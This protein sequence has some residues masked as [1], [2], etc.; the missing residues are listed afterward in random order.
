MVDE[1]NDGDQATPD[2]QNGSGHDETLEAASVPE[3]RYLRSDGGTALLKKVTLA[4]TF[5]AGAAVAGGIAAAASLD[6]GDKG[7]VVA[8]PSPSSS[9]SPWVSP[10]SSSSSS[11]SNRPSSSSSASATSSSHSGKSASSVTPSASS[12]HS[13]ASDSTSA[14]ESPTHTQPAQTAAPSADSKISP[15]AA[16][17]TQIPSPP[18]HSGG[19]RDSAGPTTG[20]GSKANGSSNSGSISVDQSRINTTWRSHIYTLRS[21]QSRYLVQ[22]GDTLSQLA[23]AMGVR[24][25]DLA[26]VN[27]ISDPNK[28]Y[29]GQSLRP[30]RGS[31]F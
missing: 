5:L 25:E 24:V 2:R 27:G 10:T 22:P 16:S 9:A 13:P 31:G 3:K 12:N 15:S 14:K 26:R 20:S 28:I 30:A 6:L 1:I 18:S 21:G 19:H 8:D 4:A 29:A 7:K 23:L 11:S 17:P